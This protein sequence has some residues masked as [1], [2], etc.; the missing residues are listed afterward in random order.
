MKEDKLEEHK[1][2][3][4]EYIKSRD[5]VVKSFRVALVVHTSNGGYIEDEY[6]FE[7]TKDGWLTIWNERSDFMN[8]DPVA[9]KDLM[10]FIKEYVK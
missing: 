1:K 8:I 3:I 5:G 10:Q 9:A 4:H 6:E 2:W 7:V